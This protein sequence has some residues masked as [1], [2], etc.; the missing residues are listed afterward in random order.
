MAIYVKNK[1][2]LEEIIR[3]QDASIGP[4]DELIKMWQKMA[5]RFSYKFTYI[6][7]D[8]RQDCM[9]QGVMDCYLYWHNFN[10]KKGTNAFA[11]FTQLIKNGF[12]KMWRKLHPLSSADFIRFSVYNI[13]SI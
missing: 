6:N 4:S 8:D 10:T 2:L 13:W 3:C 5:E 12:A 7:P 11:Y 9:A 1:D